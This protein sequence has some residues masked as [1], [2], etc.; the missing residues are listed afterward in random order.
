MHSV[1]LRFISVLFTS[2]LAVS[3]VQAGTLFPA[4]DSNDAIVTLDTDTLALNAV[5]PFGVGFSFGGLAFD[6]NTQTLYMIGGR[7]N[8]NLYTVD[9]SSGTATLVSAHGVT[10]LFGLAFDS[11]NNRLYA[12]QF[13]GGSGFYKLSQ[14]DGSATLIGDDGRPL[15]GLAYDSDSDRIIHHRP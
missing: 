7:G 6:P 12:S 4:D 2:V 14:V 3:S 10:D 8:P 9:T 1:N 5:G 15:G 13:S 11:I